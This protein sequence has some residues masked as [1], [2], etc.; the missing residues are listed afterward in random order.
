M[1]DRFHQRAV[2][3][4]SRV[5]GGDGGT[6]RSHERTESRIADRGRVELNAAVNLWVD[7][8][9]RLAFTPGENRRFEFGRGRFDERS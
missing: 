4:R 3:G 2:E 9:D 6:R 5:E 1:K 8:K 7:T